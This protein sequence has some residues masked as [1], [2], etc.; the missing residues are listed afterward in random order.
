MEFYNYILS[1]HIISLIAWMAMLFYLPRLFIYHKENIKNQGFVDVV[2]IQETKLY[3]YIGI[4]SLFAT[5]ISGTAMIMINPELFSSGGWLHAKISLVV[6][7]V[8]YHFSLKRFMDKLQD[9]ICEKSGKF[10]RIYNE[11]PTII[12]ILIVIL[13]INKPF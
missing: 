1:F 7:L 6:L 9:G 13:V 2:K 3:K 10:F 12:M 4:P 11:V 5:I 8:I